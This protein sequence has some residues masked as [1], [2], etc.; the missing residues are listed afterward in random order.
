[1]FYLAVLGLHCSDF[2]LVAVNRGYSLIAMHGFLIAV[3]SVVVEHGLEVGFRSCSS[4]ALEHKRNSC[5]AQA[6][7]LR[8]W[9]LPRIGIKTV[10]YVGRW[11]LYYWSHQESPVIILAVYI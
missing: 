2:S 6:L 4:W 8:I 1:M 11:I 3:T 7:L 9:G 10:S 5:G